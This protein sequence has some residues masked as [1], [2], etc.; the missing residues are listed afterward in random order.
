M[1]VEN[2]GGSLVWTSSAGSF[3]TLSTLSAPTLGEVNATNTVSSEISP[4]ASTATL[5]GTLTSTGG[6]N[7]DVFFVWGDND[8]GTNYSNLSNWDNQVAM[9]VLGTGSFS[10]NLTGL[11]VGKVYYF[12]T[13]ASNGSGSVVSSSLG[14]FSVSNLGNQTADF[15]TLHPANRTLWLDA[16]YSCLLYTSDAADE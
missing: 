16:N 12:R 8:A 11:D 10:S 2:A 3:T 6:D 5:N 7:P 13:A 14:I 15:S 1:A 9:G 4:P